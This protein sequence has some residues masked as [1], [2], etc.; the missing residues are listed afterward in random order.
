MIEREVIKELNK[1]RLGTPSLWIY[2]LL[3]FLTLIRETP[4]RGLRDLRLT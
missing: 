2:M 3:T 4:R 1:E